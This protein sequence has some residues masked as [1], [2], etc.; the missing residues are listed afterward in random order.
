MVG[1]GISF[2]TFNLTRLVVPLLLDAGEFNIDMGIK[3]T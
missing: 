3:E 2:A 1:A